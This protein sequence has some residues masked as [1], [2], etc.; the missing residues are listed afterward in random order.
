M[1]LSLSLPQRVTNAWL[2]LA[3]FVV[4]ILAGSCMVL[5]LLVAEMLV[6]FQAAMEAAS[7]DAKDAARER[8]AANEREGGH[9]PHSP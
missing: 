3:I 8:P 2:P 1:L 7:A 4:V 5:S 6:R 9:D